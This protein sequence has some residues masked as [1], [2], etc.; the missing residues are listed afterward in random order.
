[1]PLPSIVP[2]RLGWG[3]GLQAYSNLAGGSASVTSI[4]M[5]RGLQRYSDLT[6]YVG[7]SLCIVGTGTMSPD[8]SIMES[9]WVFRELLLLYEDAYIFV[10]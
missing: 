1:M 10:N 7:N 8:S 9:L 5:S 3:L 2:P 4:P 6:Q